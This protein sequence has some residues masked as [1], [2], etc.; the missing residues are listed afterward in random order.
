MMNAALRESVVGTTQTSGNVW[1][2]VPVE[3][4]GEH[5]PAM[6]QQFVALKV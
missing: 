1:C 6:V 4:K 3:G 2:L 5:Q